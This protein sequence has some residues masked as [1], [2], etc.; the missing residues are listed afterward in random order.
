MI[1][2]FLSFCVFW[3]PLLVAGI[4][5]LTALAHLAKKNYGLAGM[6]FCYG[7]ANVAMLYALTHG[8][9]K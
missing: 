5:L 9:G 8:E 6:W 3:M 2:K 4:Y 7:M 1:D